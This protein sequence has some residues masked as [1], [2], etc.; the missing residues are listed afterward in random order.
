MS[1]SG[2]R[3]GLGRGL[4]A[5]LADV[6]PEPSVEGPKS[7]RLV[8]IEAVEPNPDQPRKHFHKEAL[9]ELAASIGRHGII[10]PILVRPS[11]DGGYQIVAGERRWRAAQIAQLHEVPIVVRELSDTDALEVAIIENIQRS[12]LDPVEEAAGYKQLVDRFGHT[13]EEL[14]EVL[15]RSRSHIANMLRLLN[16]PKEVQDFLSSGQLTAGHARALITA[17]DPVSLARTAVARGMTVRQVEAM[18]KGRMAPA[19]DE[20]KTAKDADTESLEADLSAAVGAKVSID[21]RARGGGRLVIRY[22]DVEH[23]DALCGMLTRRSPS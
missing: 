23:L 4:S 9:E 8:P 7:D 22:K 21:H 19:A 14:A 13:Q 20:P 15:G 16:L 3:R 12:D 6:E 18:A 17:E 1:E 2:G 10:Q 5:L 11:G